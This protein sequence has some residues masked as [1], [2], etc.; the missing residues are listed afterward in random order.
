MSFWQN[1]DYL[2]NG[3]YCVFTRHSYSSVCA[4]VWRQSTEVPV[5]GGIPPAEYTAV[6][7]PLGLL[8]GMSTEVAPY[9]EVYY[10]VCY[11]GFSPLANREGGRT[12]PLPSPAPLQ[13]IVLTELLTLPSS[14]NSGSRIAKS[15]EIMATSYEVCVWGGRFLCPPCA[16]TQ[17]LT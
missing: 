17:G 2:H 7:M 11:A 9:S 8:E 10:V 4:C 1:C 12:V 6:R 5:H 13:R 3:P 15:T 16:H 14:L